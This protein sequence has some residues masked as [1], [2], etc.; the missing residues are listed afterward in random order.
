MVLY[1]PLAKKLTDSASILKAKEE[2]A[3]AINN[4]LKDEGYN[5]L[6]EDPVLSSQQSELLSDERKEAL[7]QASEIASDSL[8]AAKGSTYIDPNTV[9]TDEAQGKNLEQKQKVR[10][11]KIV[12]KDIKSFN[13]DPWDYY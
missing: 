6:E 5:Q 13:G 3:I 2:R 10:R 11:K 4:E 7:E 12:R 1:E 8:N 9:V